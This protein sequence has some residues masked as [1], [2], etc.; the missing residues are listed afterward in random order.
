[1]SYCDFNISL[2]KT[3][4]SHKM[5]IEPKL[6][7]DWE[8]INEAYNTINGI[9]LS[10]KKLDTSVYDIPMRRFLTFCKME[11]VS[12]IGNKLQGEFA[13]G[14]DRSV[15]CK[16]DFDKWTTKYNSRTENII[17]IKDAKVGHIY[18]TVCGLSVIYL[19]S[20]YVSKWKD[21]LDD[22]TKIN[23]VHY[24]HTNISFD[25]DNPKYGIQPKGTL[26]FTC[27]MG[28]A[29]D[30]DEIDNVFKHYYYSNLQL[31]YFSDVPKKNPKYGLIE[32]IEQFYWKNMEWKSHTTQVERMYVYNSLIT[33]YKNKYYLVRRGYSNDNINGAK[34]IHPETLKITKVLYFSLWNY[35]I[36][37]DSIV[38][39]KIFRIGVVN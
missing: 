6:S 27:D 2:F 29:L 11:N 35:N 18:R 13:V 38:P 26:K 16:R 20:K 31:T 28:L 1:M 22:Y 14:K 3:F 15:Y 4:I 8:L 10:S 36:N 9:A 7:D 33:Y 32:V 24:V 21:R 34:I 23:K 19:G 30:Q 12:I 37:D 25:D 17:S 5:K 39:E